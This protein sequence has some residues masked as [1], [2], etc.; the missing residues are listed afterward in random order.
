MKKHHKSR[1][2]QHRSHLCCFLLGTW[3]SKSLML[4]I[5]PWTIQGDILF[6]N[7]NTCA[8]LY[9]RWG[10]YLASRFLRLWAYPQSGS[11][12]LGH[13]TKRWALHAVSNSD[14]NLNKLK[15]SCYGFQLQ[16][17][18]WYFWPYMITNGV[19][20]INMLT[21]TLVTYLGQYIPK[22][23]HVIV[24]I[25]RLQNVTGYIFHSAWGGFAMNV[26]AFFICAHVSDIILSLKLLP[27]TSPHISVYE[28]LAIFGTKSS[29]R[30]VGRFWFL[31]PELWD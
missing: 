2:W 25:K 29:V 9:G 1:Q 19:S 23:Y 31:K 13:L 15:W 5:S 20:S 24:L 8:D 17:M 21:I 28:V 11:V 14:E 16:L 27:K 12:N 7:L 30:S 3:A 22:L 18:V 6:I 4:Y 26:T 10:V